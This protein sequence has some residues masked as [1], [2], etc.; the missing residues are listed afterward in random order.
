MDVM[1]TRAAGR[2]KRILL[3][4]MG[5][6]AAA[7]AVA[8]PAA[9]EGSFVIGDGNA[10]V[11]SEVTFWGAQWWKANP[12]STGAAPAAFKGFADSVVGTPACGEPWSTRPGNSSDPP[13]AALGELIDV[14]VASHVTKSGPVISGDTKEVVLVETAPGYAADPGH[15]GTGTVVGVLCGPSAGGGPPS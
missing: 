15:P 1:S 5:T 6:A 2:A 11:G 8:A 14:I 3:G 7:L 13:A 9:A 12:L 10:A 4:T